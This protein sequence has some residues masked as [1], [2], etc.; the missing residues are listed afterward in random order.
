MWGF[1]VSKFHDRSAQA[2]LLMADAEL[3]TP[4]LESEIGALRLSSLAP[5][6]IWAF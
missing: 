4:F 1:P 2:K 3:D 5:T 6:D